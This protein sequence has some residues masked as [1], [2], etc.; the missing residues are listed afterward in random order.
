MEEL[1]SSASSPAALD[2]IDVEQLRRQLGDDAA[3]SLE[4]LARLTKT[5][6][7]QGL[8]EQKGG[9]TELTP[10]GVRRLGQTAP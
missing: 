7:E 10:K 2:E 1:F 4:R 3:R 6:Q 8:I 5:L 9:R